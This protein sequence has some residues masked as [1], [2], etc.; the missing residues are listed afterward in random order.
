MKVTELKSEGLKKQYKVLVEAQEF[1]K[2]VD[3]KISE[4]AKTVKLPGFRAG[5][6]PLSMLKQ[7]Y[8][9]A[10]KGEVLEDLVRQ[11]ADDLIKEKNLRPAMM[12]DIKI[13]AFKDGEDI[14]DFLV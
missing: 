8:A 11:S 12:P 1:E 6:A 3:A 10:V 7:K 9:P 2:K 4:I 13:T 5:K 14:S